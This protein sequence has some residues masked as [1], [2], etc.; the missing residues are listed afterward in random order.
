M[1]VLCRSRSSV[2]IAAL[3]LLLPL[4][5]SCGEDPP[6]PPAAPVGPFFTD[7]F[8]DGAPLPR[9]WNESRG[10]LSIADFNTAP[11][12]GKVLQARATAPQRKEALLHKNL[13]PNAAIKELTCRI[14]V[15]LTK[16]GG[17]SPLSV[18]RIDVGGGAVLL[19][20]KSD[21]WSTFGRFGTQEFREGAKR[22]INGFLTTII[23]I[24][25]TGRI[26]V[27]FGGDERVK[28]IDVK[29]API[30]LRGGAIEL[31]LLAP[32]LDV[33]TEAVFDDV[34]CSQR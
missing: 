32:P 30:D 14:I 19:D 22:E 7:T 18:I 2:V 24:E 23:S 5:T 29:S 6:P 9:T 20:L 13:K 3:A 25:S 16:F 33:D 12:G 27:T 15:N 11:S 34:E 31:G 8:D 17:Q 10:D 1:L 26:V 28:H 4:L 21:E